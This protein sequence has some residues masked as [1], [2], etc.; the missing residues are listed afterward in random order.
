MPRDIFVL[1]YFF[2]GIFLFCGNFVLGYIFTSCYELIFD[3]N[4]LCL[5]I[6]LEITY[7]QMGSYSHLRQSILRQFTSPTTHFSDIRY[8]IFKYKPC[9]LACEQNSRLFNPLNVVFNALCYSFKT[10][11]RLCKLVTRNCVIT[12]IL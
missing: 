7:K 12:F 8:E 4:F 1:G 10:I 11:A 5:L 2:P 6:S 3:N 9:R